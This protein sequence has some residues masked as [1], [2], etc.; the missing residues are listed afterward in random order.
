M[1]AVL[2]AAGTVGSVML[3][4]PGAAASTVVSTGLSA[5]A[6][7]AIPGGEAVRLKER[8]ARAFNSRGYP[9]SQ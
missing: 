8:G 9:T 4:V 7:F 3:F 5:L 2:I 1:S 6:F